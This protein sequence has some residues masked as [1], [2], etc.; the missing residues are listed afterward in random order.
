VLQVFSWNPF[1][2]KER[3]AIFRLQ[4]IL[5]SLLLNIVPAFYYVDVLTWSLRAYIGNR[6]CLNEV[7]LLKISPYLV[8]R[9]EVTE[10]I[11]VVVVQTRISLR[12]DISAW[13]LSLLLLLCAL[14]AVAQTS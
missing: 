5:H 12:R 7:V 2:A 9:A 4:S 10:H 3:L 6:I 8:H 1:I 14:A 13:V 11:P